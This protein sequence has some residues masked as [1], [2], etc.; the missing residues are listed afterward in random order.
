MAPGATLTLENSTLATTGSS[1]EVQVGATLTAINSTI[2]DG[3][4]F[5]V[6]NFG[7]AS[8]LNS[9]IAFNHEVGLES[10]GEETKLTN[11]IVAENNTESKAGVDCVGTVTSSDHSLD[12][13]GTCGVGTLS[14]VNP[15]LNKSLLN[16]GGSTPVLSIK[17]GSPA[18]NASDGTALSRD[19][20]ARS[21]TAGHR[22]RRVHDRG[23]RVQQRA[24]QSD[25]AGEHQQRSGSGR[26]GRVV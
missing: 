13:D 1:V 7:K 18:I 12:S 16:N 19:R 15:L 14:K 20:P 25:G 22:G 21:A 5:G 9:T 24:P 8:F 6:I 10:D 4:A 3:R 26:R 23:G 17:P 11:T 2:A